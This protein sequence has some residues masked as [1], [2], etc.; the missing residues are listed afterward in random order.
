MLALCL[1]DV[2]FHCWKNVLG[3]SCHK[4]SRTSTRIF[5]NTTSRSMPDTSRIKVRGGMHSPFITIE[6]NASSKTKRLRDFSHRFVRCP[7]ATFIRSG[8]LIAPNPTQQLLPIPMPRN[9]NPTRP[10]TLPPRLTPLTRSIQ[11]RKREGINADFFL[12]G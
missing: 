6:R 10:A 2:S 5:Q 7:K 1:S 9:T 4:Q 3:R 11:A 12:P 8:R